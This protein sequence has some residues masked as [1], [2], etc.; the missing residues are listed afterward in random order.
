MNI[1]SKIYIAGHGGMVGSA[2]M[3]KLQECGYRNVIFRTHKELDLTMQSD[4]ETFFNSER[5][6]YVFLAAA[7]V[8]GILAN[9]T[10]KAEFIY[11]NIM[12]AANVINAS[13]K[14]GVKKLMNLGSSCIYPK[15]S[16]QPMKEEHLLTGVLEPTN[17]PYAMAK[18][19]AIKL[20]RYYNEQ[21]GTNFISVMPTNLYGL[22]DNYDL[23]T[24][25]VLPAL[26][27]KMHLGKCL[28]NGD[29]ESIRKDLLKRPIHNHNVNTM[30]DE[31]IVSLLSKYGMTINHPT[32]TQLLAFD[33][34]Y[35]TV[36]GL[37]GTGSPYREFLH[38]DDL[39][40]GCVF[41]MQKYNASDIGEIVNLGTGTD[42]QIKELAQLVK[43]VIGYKGEIRWDISKPNG[44]PKK[45]LD[46]SRI[47][48]LGWKSKID[49]RT[50]LENVYEEYSK[51]VA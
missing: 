32:N 51:E 21:Y 40:D 35:L 11:Q 48:K 27:R 8:G 2:L 30:T 43:D 20:C 5:P 25:H 15:F 26:I 29:F 22:N 14:Y 31:E 28:Q 3:R 17:E 18:I 46:I 10:Y 44:T 49:L 4:V 24:S 34:Q 12:I 45:L 42:L 41:L 16:P 33:Y 36:I 6:E 9:S 37:W 19:A 50:G 7:K 39:A 1:N 38:A 47:N 13:Y 23:E